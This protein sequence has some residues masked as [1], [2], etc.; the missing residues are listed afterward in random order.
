MC[1]MTTQ[2]VSDLLAP[3]DASGK[4]CSQVSIP[5]HSPQQIDDVLESTDRVV[6]LEKEASEAIY[7]VNIFCTFNISCFSQITYLSLSWLS[8][9]F[10]R[11]EMVTEK[12]NEKV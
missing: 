2:G 4:K 3:E 9:I 8:S 10:C 11:N 6:D 7:R 12:M 1:A 5:F